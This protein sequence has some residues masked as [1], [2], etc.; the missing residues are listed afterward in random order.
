M[1]G[2]PVVT[3]NRAVMADAPAAATGRDRRARR[4][5]RTEAVRAHLLERAG[6]LEAAAVHYRT[7]ARLATSI[8]E[9]DY[10]TTQAARLT[11]TSGG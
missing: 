1:T 4:H 6:D 9:R 5:Q 8:P 11:V 2:N 10:L 3:L 7:A